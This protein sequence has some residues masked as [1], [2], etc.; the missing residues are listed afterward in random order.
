[1]LIGETLPFV[2]AFIEKVDAAVQK[3]DPHAGLTRLQKGWLGFCMTAAHL[4][5]STWF[6]C[7][8]GPGVVQGG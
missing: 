6:V 4:S 2:T 3:I 1:M 5:G 8:E 7:L